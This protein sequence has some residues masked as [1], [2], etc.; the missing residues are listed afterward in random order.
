MVV[1]DMPPS[2]PG[3]RPPEETGEVRAD[4]R[5]DVRSDVRTDEQARKVREM[6]SAIAGR[7]DRLNHLLSFGIDRRWRT[8]AVREALAYGPRRILDVAT[9]TADLALALKAHAPQVEVIGLDFAEPMLE[10][11]RHKASR[12]QLDVRFIQGDA[13]ALPF[14]DASFDAVTVAYGLRNFADR[15]RGLREMHRVLRPG[16]RL[17]VL[18]FPPPPQGLFGRVFRTYLLSVIPAV[19]G[20]LSGQGDAYRY[21]GQSVLDFPAPQTLAAMMREVGFCRVGVRLQ[22]FGISALHRGD[23]C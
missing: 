1:W 8:E 18:E 22:T 20:R 14:D 15:A 7:Y 16:G 19:A 13:L 10:L 2:S 17:V 4:V 23:K 6:F 21:L 3:S 9:G 11:A 5:T 12:R